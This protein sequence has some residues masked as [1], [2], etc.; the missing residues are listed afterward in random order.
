MC[1]PPTR[2]IRLRPLNTLL[3]SSRPNPFSPSLRANSFLQDFVESPF[4]TLKSP[5][6]LFHST[7]RIQRFQAPVRTRQPSKMSSDYVTQKGQPFDRAAFESL[8]R[9]KVF[10]WQSFEPYG[11]VKVIL[12]LHSLLYSN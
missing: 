4:A 1:Q 5:N 6:R 2:V 9:R 7:S 12:P 11:S 8:L 10:L 3:F